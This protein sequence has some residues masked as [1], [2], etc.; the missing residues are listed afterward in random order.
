MS[1][2]ESSGICGW[3]LITATIGDGTMGLLGVAESFAVAGTSVRLTDATPESIW[4]AGVR[5]THA[6]HPG[7]RRGGPAGGG[8]GN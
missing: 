2:T 8:G 6:A 4:E 1:E 3:P 7:A 5:A